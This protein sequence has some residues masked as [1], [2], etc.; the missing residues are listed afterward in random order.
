MLTEILFISLIRLIQSPDEYN[1][2]QVR[3]IG[4]AKLE[5][6]AKA[7]YVTKE[8]YD[9]AIT[10]NAIWLDVDLTEGVRKLNKKYVLVE[11]VF[12]KDKLGHLRMYSGT[13]KAVRRIEEWSRDA[14]PAGA[15]ADQ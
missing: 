3:V 13:I 8:D 12:D 15:K 1:L 14:K 5:F 11:G 10:K 9:N 6:E 7:L 4:F 2:K